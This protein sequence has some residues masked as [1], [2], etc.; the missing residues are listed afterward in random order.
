[1]T[2]ENK[3]ASFASKAL[4]PSLSWEVVSTPL[5]RLS[6]S[7]LSSPHPSLSGKLIARCPAHLPRAGRDEEE[8]MKLHVK[9]TS[10][11]TLISSCENGENTEATVPRHTACSERVRSALSMALRAN[12][13]WSCT[14]CRTCS[15]RFRPRHWE[16]FPS[17]HSYAPV[18]PGDTSY[19]HQGPQLLKTQLPKRTDT[20]G[21]G[22]CVRLSRFPGDGV[23][24][25]HTAPDCNTVCAVC[26]PITRIPPTETS[27]VAGDSFASPDQQ[28]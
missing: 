12:F 22:M 13:H 24:L 19:A 8:K 26:L 25:P 27:E 23:Q 6:P 1:M 4:H 15:S 3:G 9:R 28:M 2:E 18:E 20:C 14:T 11:E 17:Q 16:R 21:V 10:V 5:S 7:T